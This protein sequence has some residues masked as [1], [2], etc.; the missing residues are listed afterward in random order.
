MKGLSKAHPI[1]RFILEEAHRQDM[2]PIELGRRAGVSDCV[3]YRWRHTSVP[4]LVNAEACLN[5]LGFHLAIEQTVRA[6]LLAVAGG[7]H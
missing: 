3:I 4:D 7:R 5:V 1:G 2:S 6:E